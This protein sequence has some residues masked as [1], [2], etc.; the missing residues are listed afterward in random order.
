MR[1][2]T[3][4]PDFSRATDSTTPALVELFAWTEKEF[5]KR[6][7][8]SAIR[9]I[10]Y[11]RWLRNIAVALGNAPTHCRAIRAALERRRDDPSSAGARTRGVGHCA[12]SERATA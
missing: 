11:E 6:T 10:G 12:R 2:S 4:E 8:G 1:D 3:A 9:R 7:A 5:L